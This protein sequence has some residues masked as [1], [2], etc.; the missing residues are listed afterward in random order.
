MMQEMVRIVYLMC[1]T[2]TSK[3]NPNKLRIDRSQYF[4]TCFGS[5]WNGLFF[6]KKKGKNCNK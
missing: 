6:E 4:C 2:T 5:A 1:K 3:N